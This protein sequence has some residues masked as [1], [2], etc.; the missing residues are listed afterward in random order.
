MFF[1][2]DFLEFPYT[3]G[4]ECPGSVLPLQ[5]LHGSTL[6]GSVLTWSFQGVAGG[7]RASSRPG[8]GD[9]WEDMNALG[10]RVVSGKG[11]GSSGEECNLA[12]P[13]SCP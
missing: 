4:R 7:L 11:V 12:V 13:Y 3:I 5:G 8:D 2:S 10:V 6:W 1:F 9:D